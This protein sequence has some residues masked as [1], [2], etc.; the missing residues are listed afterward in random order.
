MSDKQVEDKYRA[1]A[2]EILSQREV[3]AVAQQT[4]AIE[5]QRSVRGLMTLLA[6]PEKALTAAQ[7]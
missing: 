2:G 4:W 1:L 7:R 6:G 3:D 5:K